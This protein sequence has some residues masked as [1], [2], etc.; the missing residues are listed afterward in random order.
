MTPDQQLEK[1]IKE[2]FEKENYPLI[3]KVLEQSKSTFP[4]YEKYQ[5][6]LENFLCLHK[7]D[8]NDECQACSGYD[9]ACQGYCPPDWLEGV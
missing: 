5:K 7:S 1:L 3:G 4:K 8:D 6:H 2:L 9:Q